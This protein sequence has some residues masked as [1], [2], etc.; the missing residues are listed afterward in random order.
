MSVQKPQILTFWLIGGD[1]ACE[2]ALSGGKG[3]REP[4]TMSQR[5]E[6]HP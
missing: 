1:L 2:Q 4:A 5:F 6:F 3:E